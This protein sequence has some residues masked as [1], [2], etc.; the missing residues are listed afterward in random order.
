MQPS[1]SSARWLRAEPTGRRPGPAGCLG[2]WSPRQGHRQSPLQPLCSPVARQEL[3]GLPSSRPA[4]VRAQLHKTLGG[5]LLGPAPRPQSPTAGATAVTQ[6]KSGPLRP[7]SST[8]TTMPE[9]TCLSTTQLLV[10][11]V[12]WPPG[13]W[14]F[15]NCSSSSC[16][17][18]ES[19]A[20]RSFLPAACTRV[21]TVPGD[22][23]SSFSQ[24]RSPQGT[25]HTLVSGAGKRN[26]PEVLMARRSQDLDQTER[27]ALQPRLLSRL[28]EYFFRF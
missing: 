19:S 2:A 23:S 8:L 26:R 12:A 16:S 18:R 5:G 24:S 1:E 7:P 17:S 25:G 14:P 28:D 3:W 13:P 22:R 9:G 27:R 20:G 6:E 21:A 15:T 11:L 4:A 10:L